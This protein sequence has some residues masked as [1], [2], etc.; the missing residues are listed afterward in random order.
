[1]HG[2]FNLDGTRRRERDEPCKS[3]GAMIECDVCWEHTGDWSPFIIFSCYICQM[4]HVAVDGGLAPRR[5]EFC[6]ADTP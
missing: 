3:C 1:M 4:P 2:L 5:C 6:G